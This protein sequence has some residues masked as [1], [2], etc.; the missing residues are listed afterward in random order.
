MLTRFTNLK[1]TAYV[2]KNITKKRSLHTTFNKKPSS[3]LNNSG[4][5]VTNLYVFYL[6]LGFTIPFLI[7]Y[8]ASQDRVNNLLTN[9]G[10]EK[11][12]SEGKDICAE[13]QFEMD[14]K[15]NNA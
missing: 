10:L 5:M 1:T 8:Q 11:N 15:R 7:S 9:D 14:P 13:C 3:D 6:S 12:M 4:S 2:A